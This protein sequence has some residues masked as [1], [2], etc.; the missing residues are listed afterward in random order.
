M[1][2]TEPQAKNFADVCWY[3]ISSRLFKQR[4]QVFRKSTLSQS[5]VMDHV[6]GRVV[7]QE[8]M[9]RRNGNFSAAHHNRDTL[10]ESVCKQHDAFSKPHIEC[11]HTLTSKFSI[12]KMSDQYFVTGCFSRS[13]VKKI[14]SQPLICLSFH[15]AVHLQTWGASPGESCGLLVY[16]YLRLWF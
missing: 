5:D 6:V 2:E 9:L 15:L 3:H 16:C 4:L 10:W 14:D 1:F 13:G 8:M 7:V 12:H 11:G